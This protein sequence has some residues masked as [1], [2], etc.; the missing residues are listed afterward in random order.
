[1]GRGAWSSIGAVVAKPKTG[2]L[3]KKLDDFSLAP[4]E[5]AMR[6]RIAIA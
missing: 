1:M 4:P 6:P 5:L 2:Q 3:T